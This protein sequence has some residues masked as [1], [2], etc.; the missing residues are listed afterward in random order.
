MLNKDH[1]Q[2]IAAKLKARMHAG[3]AHDIA[4]IEY[5]GKIIAEFGIRRGSRKDQGHGFIPGRLHL[6]LRDTLSMAQCAL[7]YEQWIQRMK[8]KGLIEADPSQETTNSPAED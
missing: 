1:A 4:V 6:N 2:K 3:S 5:A 8:E 7:S